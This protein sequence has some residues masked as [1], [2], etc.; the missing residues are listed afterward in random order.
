MVQSVRARCDFGVKKR[1]LR[2]DEGQQYCDIRMKGS[3]KRQ[4]L[5]FVFQ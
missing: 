4:R 2:Q 3:D 5:Y 1:K